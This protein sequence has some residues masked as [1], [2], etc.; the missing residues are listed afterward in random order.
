VLWWALDLKVRVIQ[1][2][3]RADG[4]SLDMGDREQ[5]RLT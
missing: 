5:K 4:V 2:K 1:D 3:L